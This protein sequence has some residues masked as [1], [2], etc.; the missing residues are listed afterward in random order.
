MSTLKHFL[1][2][3]LLQ[4]F[5]TEI[6]LYSALRPGNGWLDY[7]QDLL[8]VYFLYFYF[9]WMLG[10]NI[11][12]KFLITIYAKD[13]SPPYFAAQRDHRIHW[14]SV[15]LLNVIN[16]GV[17]WQKIRDIWVFLFFVIRSSRRNFP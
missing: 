3:V 8:N 6:T 14:L 9:L 15:D 10:I 13:S 11:I 4:K 5:G 16:P 2:F 1:K 7:G 17:H 12:I